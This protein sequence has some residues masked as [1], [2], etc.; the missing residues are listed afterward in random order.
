VSTDFAI[1]EVR[2]KHAM[3]WRRPLPGRGALETLPHADTSGLEVK[4]EVDPRSDMPPALD[5]GELGSCTANATGRAFRYDTIKDGKDCGELSRLWIY[6]FERALEHTLGQGDT[7]ATGHDAY[8]VAL[9]GIPAEKDYPYIV[10]RYDEK[11]PNVQPRAYKLS[12]PVHALRPAEQDFDRAL[13][14]GQTISYGFTVYE[15]FEAGDWSSTSGVMPM[16]GR[17]EG[18]LGG[19]ENLICGYLKDYPDDYLSLNSWSTAWGIFG[20]Y[21]LIPKAFVLQSGAASDFR[22]IV[23]AAP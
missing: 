1:P 7:G 23:R 21:F 18:V 14:N 15:S 20:G 11:P 16:P 13:S 8:R 3:G 12:K 17:G 4:P 6:Y 22:T 2:R 10:G 9:H 19:H 5:Q